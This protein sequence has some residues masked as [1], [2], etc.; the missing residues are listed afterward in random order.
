MAKFIKA[1]L[2]F[3]VAFVISPELLCILVALTVGH[4]FG[5]RIIA[6]IPETAF[7]PDV[8]KWAALF[9]L[10]PA[11][12]SI[13]NWRELLSPEHKASSILA[14]WPDRD[15]LFMTFVVGILYQ[16]I[17]AFTAVIFWIFDSLIRTQYGLSLFTF[18]ILGSLV[19]A[20]THYFAWIRLRFFLDT[21][22]S[23]PN[24]KLRN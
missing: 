5:A 9:A 10:V 14:D 23:H 18:S 17:F 15:R 6:A 20:A 22:Q 11:G 2:A 12:F 8:M 3:I 19:S 24:E 21:I 16:V 4:L 13:K 1:I 7:R